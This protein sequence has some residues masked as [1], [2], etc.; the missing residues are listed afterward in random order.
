MKID[1][2][3]ASY[4]D[5]K[6]LARLQGLQHTATLP[7]GTEIWTP[8]G[9][10]AALPKVFD[11][12]QAAHDYALITPG[13]SLVPEFIGE[14]PRPWTAESGAWHDPTHEVFHT[15]NVNDPFN[16]REIGNT[17]GGTN[18]LSS[19]YYENDGSLWVF[20]R[21]T[22][23]KKRL[24]DAPSSDKPTGEDIEFLKTEALDGGKGGFIDFFLVDG[25]VQSY[26]RSAAETVIQE[27]K[28]K[29]KAEGGTFYQTSPGRYDFVADPDKEFAPGPMIT[30]PGIG[31]MVQ[32]SPNQYQIIEDT[33]EPGVVRD[34]ISGRRY[35]QQTDGNWGAEV[36]PVYD[37]ELQ[38]VDGMSLFQQ[39]SGDVSQLTPP[40]MDDIITQALIDGEYDKAF[41]F[42]DFRD[43]PS[44]QETF[45]TALEFARSPADQVLIS[46][47]ARGEQF[48]APPPEGEIQRVGPQPDFLVQAY[49]DFQRR[50]QA[51]RAPTD[52][53]ATD[54]SARAAAGQSPLTDNLQTR[55]EELKIENQ[56]FKNEAISL[57]TQQDQQVFQQNNKSLFGGE[58]ESLTK[59]KNDLGLSSGTSMTEVT[60]ESLKRIIAGLPDSQKEYAASQIDS[61]YNGELT[62]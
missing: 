62:A 8:G 36:K 23:E 22:G 40:N 30:L 61:I 27:G 16:I 19:P 56:Q 38:R 20:N 3:K 35:I 18:V 25:K 28:D 12:V 31:K 50:T 42:Q 52:E 14:G 59:L 4:E 54:L 15:G 44:A 11:S 10:A 7:D 6:A 29:F 34:P 26:T 51:G 17:Q 1:P 24:T 33:V 60:R 57:K 41:A 37:P 43:R 2:N 53:E 58:D 21:Q 32:T 47:I 45:Q 49:Q 13:V 46:A 9:A 39:R 55:L 48:V 5:D